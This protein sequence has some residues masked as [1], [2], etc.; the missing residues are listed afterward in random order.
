MIALLALL[1]LL[2]QQ[3]AMAS[4]ICPQGLRADTGTVATTPADHRASHPCHS[5]VTADAAR[6]EQH[7]HPTDASVD[8]LPALSVPPGLFPPTTWLRDGALID[9]S[10]PENARREP[11][12]RATA[13]PLTIQHC[14][15]Q[16]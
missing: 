15:F 6:C 3:L 5:S 2:F 16:I 13:P 7:C 11:I 12:V 9:A 10:V 1:G 14:T 4:Y 8:H